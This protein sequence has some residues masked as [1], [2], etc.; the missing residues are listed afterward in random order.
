MEKRLFMLMLLIVSASLFAGCSYMTDFAVANDSKEP[1][2]V[3]YKIKN[4][5]GPF[6][7]PTVP[8]TIATSQLSTKGNQPWSQLSSSQY[9]LDAENRTVIVRVT[10]GQ[11]LRVATMHHYIGHDDPVDAA[12]FPIE[13][14]SVTGSS[15]QV[16]LL[17]EQARV[18]FSEISR[19]LYK[20]TYK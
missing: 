1:I 15:G 4:Y 19:V 9:Q 20:L 6:T 18:A 17:G 2:E 13:E 5:P 10:P 3:R 16:K 12:N 8:A 11:A 14:I 7:P